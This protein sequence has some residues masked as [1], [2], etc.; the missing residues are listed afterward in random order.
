MFQFSK[1]ET[2]LEAAKFLAVHQ[3]TPIF[4]MARWPMEVY[5][6]GP[7][8]SAALMEAGRHVATV[9]WSGHVDYMGLA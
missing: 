3:A 8:C 1:E 7:R 5:S 9:Y 6:I 2:A 4:V